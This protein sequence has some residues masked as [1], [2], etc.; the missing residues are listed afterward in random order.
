MP[1]ESPTQWR[2]A[3]ARGARQRRAWLERLARHPQ[4]A[5]F[6]R[7]MAGTLPDA[8]HDAIA[9]LKAEIAAS[10]PKLATRQSS[11]KVLEALVPAMPE[12]IG[13]SADLTGSNLT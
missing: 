2:A 6:E 5:E 7:V 10:K 13:G 9:A 3:G 8:S 4:R 11:Q 1:D 12:L